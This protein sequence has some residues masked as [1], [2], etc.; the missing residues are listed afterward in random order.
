MDNLISGLVAAAIFIPF[1]VGLA[2][3]I[4]AAPFA[5]IV[6]IVVAML[7]VDYFQSARD[8]L[9]AEGLIKTAIGNDGNKNASGG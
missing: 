3:S 5:I 9:R 4:G 8:G 7:L 6:A 1:V 2:V